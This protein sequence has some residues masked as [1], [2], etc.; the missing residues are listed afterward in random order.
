MAATDEKNYITPDGFTALKAEFHQ[1]YKIERPEVV[2]TVSWAASNGDRSENGDFYGKRR[3]RQI[4]SRCR[5]LMRRMDLAEIVDASAQQHLEKIYFGAW[6]TLFNLDDETEHVYRIVGKD[7]LEPSKGYISWV[8]PLAK[9]MLGK[10]V[11]DTVRATT[12]KGEESF[13][14]IDVRY[15]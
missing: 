10:A 7:E 3:L 12:P 13:E 1:L 5:H 4:D 11:G 15:V 8:S 2:R 6:V 14:V 9:S